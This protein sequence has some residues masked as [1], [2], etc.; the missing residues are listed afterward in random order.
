MAK[1]SFID[2]GREYESPCCPPS[3]SKVAKVSYP[4]LYISGIEGLDLETGEITFTAKGKVVS[5]SRRNSESEGEH[6]SCEIEVHKISI[7]G[8]RPEDGLERSLKK[9]ESSKME[10]NDD[11]D[12]EDE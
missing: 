2:L 4:C 8:A 6:Y 9:I 3:K 5:V 12:D 11:G 7:P 1:D 10:R